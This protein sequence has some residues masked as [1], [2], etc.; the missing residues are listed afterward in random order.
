MNCYASLIALLIVC[1]QSAV[2][3][4]PITGITTKNIMYTGTIDVGS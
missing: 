1:S 3:L 2:V 4:N